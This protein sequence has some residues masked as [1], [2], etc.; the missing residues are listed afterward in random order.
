MIYYSYFFFE[1]CTDLFA[2]TFKKNE[3]IYFFKKYTLLDI[4]H[5]LYITKLLYLR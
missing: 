2:T 3:I 1:Q 4:L 5:I